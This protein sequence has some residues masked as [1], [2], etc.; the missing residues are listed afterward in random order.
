M[1]HTLPTD[2]NNVAYGTIEM[3][4][5]QAYGTNTVST[6]PNVAYGTHPPQTHDYEYAALP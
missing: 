2:P 1:T 4:A 5:N 6:D 3:D